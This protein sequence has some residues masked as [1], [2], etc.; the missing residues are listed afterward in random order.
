MDELRF[1]PSFYFSN[2]HLQTIVPALFRKVEGVQ[3]VRE[4][5]ETPDNDFIDIDWSK[6]GHKKL[7][8]LAHG[9]EGNSHSQYIK[10]LVK[11]LNLHHFDTVSMNFRGCSGEPNR[12]LTSYHSGKS[13]DIKF[14]VDT[15]FSRDEYDSIYLIGFSLGGNASL[16]FLGENTI[17][18]ITKAIAISVPCDLK[19]SAYTLSKGFNRIYI[20]RFLKRLKHKARTKEK[21][22]PNVVD[23]TKLYKSTN[24]LMFDNLYTAPIHGFK[25]AEDYWKKC[26]SKQFIPSITTPTLLINALNDPF[27]PKECYPYEACENNPH[28][29]FL[30][31]KFGG[32]VGF[33]T[34]VDNLNYYEKAAIDFFSDRINLK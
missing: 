33:P 31:P 10:G 34:L 30:T 26:S 3:Y 23:Y 28:V 13:D 2:K 8:I 25:D 4:R 20:N 27:L 16:K 32:H 11:A 19:A 29:T 15:L 21:Q 1:K 12:L 6:K 18:N 14:V 24:F 9:L 5:L 7:V 17:T 22:Y